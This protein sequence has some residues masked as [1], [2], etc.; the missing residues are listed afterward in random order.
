MADSGGCYLCRHIN[1]ARESRVLLTDETG[2]RLCQGACFE[3]VQSMRDVF[4]PAWEPA[5]T[6]DV[7][8][9]LMRLASAR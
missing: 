9:R 6:V 8:A 5:E 7:L 1:G 2:E 4:D 3:L